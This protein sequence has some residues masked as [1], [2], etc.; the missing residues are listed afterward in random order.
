MLHFE[1]EAKT[2]RRRTQI[3]RSMRLPPDADVES[4]QLVVTHENGLLTVSIP[5]YPQPE[6]RALQI[7][8]SGSPSSKSER[9]QVFPRRPT[10]S[11]KK[12]LPIGCKAA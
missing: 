12:N 2:A 11:L 5:K 10:S 9:A 8:S 4:D 1:G 7:C 6:S 3:E